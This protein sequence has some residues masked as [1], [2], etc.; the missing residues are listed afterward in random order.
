MLPKKTSQDTFKAIEPS[1]IQIKK[2]SGVEAVAKLFTTA[3]SKLD[4]FG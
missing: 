2:A 4:D 1:H 3:K